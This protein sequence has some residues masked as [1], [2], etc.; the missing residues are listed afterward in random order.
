MLIICFHFYRLI[1]Y[2]LIVFITLYHNLKLFWI[3]AYVHQL[4]QLHPLLYHLSHPLLIVLHSVTH[5]IPHTLLYL[6]GH[7][8]SHPL[9]YLSHQKH[10]PNLSKL[11]PTQWLVHVQLIQDV[12]L[13]SVHYLDIL[14][15]SKYYLVIIH[16]LFILC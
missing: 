7:L 10:V 5:F 14:V 2:I 15:N 13:L 8:L 3:K 4:H 16:Q 6:V 11:L 9:L 1:Y 12:T